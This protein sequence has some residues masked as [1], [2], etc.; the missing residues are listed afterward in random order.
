M[1]KRNKIVLPKD[2][3]A[4]LLKQG[5]LTNSQR[6]VELVQDWFPIDEE[7][8]QRKSRTVTRLSNGW[9]ARR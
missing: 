6:D 5:A 8:C 7:A 9:I 3:L 4:E 1:N 2:H